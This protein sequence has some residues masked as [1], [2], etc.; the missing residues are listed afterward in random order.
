LIW[1]GLHSYSNNHLNLPIKVVI[2]VERE[3]SDLE[4]SNFEF[5][6]SNVERELGR[7]ITQIIRNSKFVIHH[8]TFVIRHFQGLTPHSHNSF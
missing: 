7:P 8:S 5:R 1:I 3:G 2:L 6:I 4:M